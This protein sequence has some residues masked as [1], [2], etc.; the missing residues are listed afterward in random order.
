MVVGMNEAV[1]FGLVLYFYSK[2][3]TRIFMI[4]HDQSRGRRRKIQDGNGGDYLC[5]AFCQFEWEVINYSNSKLRISVKCFH[6][7]TS[8]DG[9]PSG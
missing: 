7:Y 6:K 8:D 1:I 5:Y 3:E 2:M 4:N 9:S